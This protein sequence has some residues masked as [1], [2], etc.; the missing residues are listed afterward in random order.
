MSFSVEN[1][2]GIFSS[3]VV[4]AIED[5]FG[6]G[7]K[8]EPIVPDWPEVSPLTVTGKG[9]IL[10]IHQLSNGEPWVNVNPSDGSKLGMDLIPSRVVVE[11]N[12]E[13]PQI[14]IFENEIGAGVVLPKNGD[15]VFQRPR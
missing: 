6:P 7:S 13:N 11:P 4:K 10:D 9:V 14:V 12:L 15:V 3:E 1:K 8:M 2:P 5:V